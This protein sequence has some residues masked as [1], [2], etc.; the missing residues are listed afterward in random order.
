M[1][2]ELK[3]HGTDPSLIS[4]VYCCALAF[5]RIFWTIARILFDKISVRGTITVV[6]PVRDPQVGVRAST[7]TR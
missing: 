3:G 4:D 2:H 6:R 5:R 7:K 1:K